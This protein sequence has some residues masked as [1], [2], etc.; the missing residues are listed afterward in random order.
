[1]PDDLPGGLTAREWEVLSAVTEG[2][3]N[4]EVAARLVISEKTV[5]RHLANVFAKVGV[6]SRTAAAAWARQQQRS[7]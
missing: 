6:S 2:L 4:R 3:S 1:M 5:A 7:R